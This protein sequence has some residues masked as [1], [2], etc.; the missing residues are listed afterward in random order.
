MIKY[1]IIYDNDKVL[2]VGR[3]YLKDVVEILDEAGYDIKEIDYRDDKALANEI[4]RLKLCGLADLGVT[5]D[6]VVFK[7][8][9]VTS[10]LQFIYVNPK[11]TDKLITA[12]V[13]SGYYISC[14]IRRK[15]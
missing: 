6:K 10:H 2:R 12:L 4:S 8:E 13:F 1:K 11:F 14:I 5:Y 15:K 7:E 9:V 3:R